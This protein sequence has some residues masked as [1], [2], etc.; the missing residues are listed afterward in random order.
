MTTFPVGPILTTQQA[1]SPSRV[2]PLMTC[3]VRPKNGAL[4]F[5]QFVVR[6]SDERARIVACPP[7]PVALVC[8]REDGSLEP[9][10][11]TLTSYRPRRQTGLRGP[12]TAQREGRSALGCHGKGKSNRLICRDLRIVLSEVP[13]GAVCWWTTTMPCRMKSSTTR[14]SLNSPPEPTGPIDTFQKACSIETSLSNRGCCAAATRTQRRRLF[15]RSSAR[16]ARSW[17]GR[18]AGSRYLSFP[19]CESV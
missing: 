8:L 7:L 10:E 2:S 9:S 11:G 16:W 18:L 1:A 6:N 15:T 12:R 13:F 5:G 3:E 19:A 14:R 17:W 4:K